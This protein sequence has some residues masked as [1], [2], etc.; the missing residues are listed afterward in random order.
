M[1]S[2]HRTLVAIEAVAL[3]LVSYFPIHGPRKVLLR[4]AGA[5]VGKTTVLYHGFQVRAARN[6]SIGDDSSIGDRAILDGRGGLTIGRSVNLSTGVQI[7]TAQ[8][9]WQSPGFE[10]VSAP[11]VIGDRVWLGPGV[12]VLP[13]TS[14]GEGAVVGAGAVVTKDLAPYGLYGGVPAKRIGDRP[15]PMTYTIGGPRRKQ[16]W[17]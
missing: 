9:D 6:L 4:I 10:S 12:I 3:S 7:W 15:E 5:Q 13:G 2:V 14:I 8:H 1:F 17:W 16:W 11:V